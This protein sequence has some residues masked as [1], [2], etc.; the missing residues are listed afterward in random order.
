MFEWVYK[1]IWAIATS[2]IIISSIYFTFKLRFIQFDFKKIFHHLIQIQEKSEI[3]SFDILMLTLAGRI[4]VGSIAGVAL[5]IYIGGIGSIFWLWF[6][7]ILISVLSYCETVLGMTYRKKKNNVFV[8]G[9]SYYIEKGLGNKKLA[10]CYA[11]LILFCYIG[12]FLGI[13]SNTITKSFMEILPISKYVVASFLFLFT[14]LI[15]FGG[16]KK[17][18]KATSFLVP[19]MT[20]FYLGCAAYICIVHINSIPMIFTSIL[21]EAFRFDSF[22]GGFLT[23][24]IVGLQ[25]G[26][27]SNES[28]L[29]TGSIA[30]SAVDS[31]N[32][33][34]QGYIQIF[35]VYITSLLICT[36]TVI[37]L[38]TSDYTSFTYMDVNGIEMMD[39]A[40]SY[41]FGEF[42]QFILFVFIFLFAFSTILTGYYYVESV[43]YFLF[44]KYSKI[45][46]VL[47]KIITLSIVFLGCILSSTFL[48]NLVDFLVAFLA[49]INVYALISLKGDIYQEYC[50]HKKKSVIK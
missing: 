10:V 11:L 39:R 48:W 22:F 23:T 43:F 25:R 20:L 2:S 35:G 50:S 31:N 33:S 27:F 41:H 15:I 32:I 36:A 5:G 14:L 40:F 18:T 17:I 42:G 8:G 44:D 4:G 37:I 19:I 34:K 9:P 46:L 47:L 28:G 30:S 38:L 1:I 29:G 7:A 6:T 13:Q 24:C 26:L 3:S 49:I 21:K 45:S 16:I 12:G